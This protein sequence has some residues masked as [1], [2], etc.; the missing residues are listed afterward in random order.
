MAD[1]ATNGP[2]LSHLKAGDASYPN[3]S[4]NGSTNGTGNNPQS[5]SGPVAASNSK[6]SS[7]ADQSS[8]TNNATDATGYLDAD[9]AASSSDTAAAKKRKKEALKPI[10]TSDAG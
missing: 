10:I 9:N 6:N 7:I 8:T 5:N 1:V 2:T 3:G 4:T